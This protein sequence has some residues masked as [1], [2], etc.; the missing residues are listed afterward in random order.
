VWAAS[1][2]GRRRQAALLEHELPINSNPRRERVASYDSRRKALQEAK[3]LRCR[4]NEELLRGCATPMSAS[5]HEP[6]VVLS[7]SSLDR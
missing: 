5:S 2:N 7:R 3:E 4:A 6:H 1:L